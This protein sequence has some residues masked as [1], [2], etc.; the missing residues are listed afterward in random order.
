MEQ[1]AEREETRGGEKVWKGGRELYEVVPHRDN[2][3]GE[4][5]IEGGMGIRGE[6]GKGER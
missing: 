5:K 6:Q 1:R 3:E 2:T 4:V